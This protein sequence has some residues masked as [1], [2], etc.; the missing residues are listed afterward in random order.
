MESK[1]N[2][3][4]CLVGVSTERRLLFP[5]L[6]DPGAVRLFDW[7]ASSKPGK[8]SSLIL[9]A[10]LLRSAFT[11]FP[12]VSKDDNSLDHTAPS[13]VKPTFYVNS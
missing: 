1:L 8:L 3:I 12:W 11:N 13:F 2:I 10:A 6:G 9:Y 4:T 7:S 5:I